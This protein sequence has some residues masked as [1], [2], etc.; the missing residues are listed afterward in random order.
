MYLQ[1]GVLFVKKWMLFRDAFQINRTDGALVR[2]T[3][4]IFETESLADA[5]NRAQNFIKSARPK[6]L[7]FLPGPSMEKEG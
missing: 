6:L 5:E 4:P 3:T 2:V 7:E 1:S